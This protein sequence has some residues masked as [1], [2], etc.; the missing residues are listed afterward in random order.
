MVFERIA[1]SAFPPIRAALEQDRNHPADRDPFLLLPEVT[2]LLHD[3]RP[4][5]GVGEGMDQLVALVHHAYLAWDAG[6]ITVPLPP[7]RIT[8]LLDGRVPADQEVGEPPRAF[9][10]QF[11]ELQI[12]AA[13]LEGGTPEPLDGCFIHSAPGG[14]L[15]V[16]GIFGFRLDRA[17]F[18]AVEAVGPKPLDLHRADGSPLFS[19]ILDGGAAGHFYSLTGAEELLELGW[20]VRAIAGDAAVQSR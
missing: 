14:T 10:A 4:A 16:L 15:R 19:S 6:T 7:D 12:W 3:L 11:H 9:Y 17:G 13:V 20:R 2:T 1:E 18:S 8:D 5:E